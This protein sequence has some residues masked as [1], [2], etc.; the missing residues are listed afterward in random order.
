MAA[1][2]GAAAVC[3]ALIEHLLLQKPTQYW[4]YLRLADG[5]VSA[6]HQSPASVC[7]QL[8]SSTLVA[9]KLSSLTFAEFGR[10]W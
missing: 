8:H 2:A 4:P 9:E 1:T 7:P 3:V 10:L 5:L 6:V